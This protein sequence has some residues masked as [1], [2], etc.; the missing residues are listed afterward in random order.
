MKTFFVA[1]LT[2]LLIQSLAASQDCIDYGDYLH[3]VGNA[4][5][6]GSAYVVAVA[7][8]Y[9]CMASDGSSELA[10]AWQQCEA[11][12]TIENDP[13]QTNPDEQIPSPGLRLTVHPN[14]FNPQ[15]TISFSLERA[16][17]A[18]VR[19]YEL[20]G[21]RVAVLAD[22]TF[23]GGEHSLLWNGR[24]IAGRSMPSGTYLVRLE[25]ESAVRVQK[26]MLIR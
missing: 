17:W 24:D 22:R 3:R 23:T 19:L 4:D 2:V 1:L 8:P 5:T 20:T 6:P 18:K 9:I 13:E 7:E 16:E 10:I 15:T 21:K 11:P 14:P 26:L 12:V 25:T